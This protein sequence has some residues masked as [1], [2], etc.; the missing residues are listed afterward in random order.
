MNLFK[1]SQLVAI[2]VYAACGCHNVAALPTKRDAFSD[3]VSSC[4]SK[5]CIHIG[6]LQSGQSEGTWVYTTTCDKAFLKPL[7][8]NPCGVE[9]SLEG[10]IYTL[11]GCGGP[12]SVNSNGAEVAQCQ[13]YPHNILEWG[14]CGFVPGYLCG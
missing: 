1:A 14:V 4:S 6:A 7:N 8:Q 2:I 3:L 9:F 11:E 12:I 13:A 10:N 5:S